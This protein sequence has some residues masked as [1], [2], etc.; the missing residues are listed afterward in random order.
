MKQTEKTIVSSIDETRFLEHLKTFFSTSVTVLAECM[1]NS[2][3]AGATSVS[4]DYDAKTSNLTITDDGSGIDDFQNLVTVARSGWS[5]T[6]MDSERPFGIGFFSVCFAG[7]IVDVESRGKKISFSSQDLIAKRPIPVTPGHFIGGVRITLKGCKLKTNELH[8]ALSKYASGFAIPVIWQGKELPRPYAQENLP[9]VNTPVGFVFDAGVHGDRRRNFVHYR[10]LVF[11][12]GLPVDVPG[13]TSSCYHG[14][15]NIIHVDSLKYQP[16][17]PDRDCLIDS[18]KAVAEF[19]E[20]LRSIWRDYLIAE[21]ARMSDV[22][23]VNTHW[24]NAHETGCSDLMLDVPVLPRMALY[25]TTQDVWRYLY[26]DNCMDQYDKHITKAEVESG[27]T[28]VFRYFDVTAHTDGFAKLKWAQE[29]GAVFIQDS[30][31]KSAGHWVEPFLKD[32][33]EASAKIDGKP[34]KADYFEGNWVAG[35]I[36]LMESLS[37]CID[38]V[39]HEVQEAI[40]LDI[41]S[42]DSARYWDKVFLVPKCDVYP[43]DVIHQASSY[44][45]DSGHYDESGFERDEAA[46]N[47]LVAIMSGEEGEKTLEKCLFEAGAS[48]KE[49]L[50]GAAFL[51]E[52]DQEG[53]VT[54]TTKS[55]Q[56][57]QV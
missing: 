51:V 14:N 32:L 26:E 40:A 11:C 34:L 57:N 36:R 56:T 12:Q 35:E 21:K 19:Q 15:A 54:V 38:G 8:T 46:F 29:A 41:N 23:F 52:F 33:S 44:L 3:R 25:R 31:W 55:D 39:T 37:V 49:N 43:G 48:F 13:F 7:K 22:E 5:Q 30:S 17:I 24:K 27:E 1:Q 53:K 47:N 4:F 6:V 10:G 9:G 42:D 16:R 2:R 20:A 50:R 18:D 28:P 45:D